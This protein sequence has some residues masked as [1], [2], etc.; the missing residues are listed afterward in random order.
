MSS[1][2]TTNSIFVFVL[3]Q[4][5]TPT[6]LIRNCDEVGLFDDLQQLNPFEETF[7]RALPKS[8]SESDVNILTIQNEDTLHT[9]NVMQYFRVT[10]A[11]E[12]Q[13]TD[14]KTSTE[15]KSEDKTI[16][17]E[18]NDKKLKS[19]EISVIKTNIQATNISPA[20]SAI[21]TTAAVVN[22]VSAYLIPISKVDSTVTTAN[23]MNKPLKRLCPKVS[24]KKSVIVSNPVK[25]KLKEMLIKT[26]SSPT[27]NDHVII[28]E[29]D[30]T[31]NNKQTQQKVEN[32]STQ[33]II[34]TTGRQGASKTKR[35]TSESNR[36]A[37]QRYRRKM[38]KEQ[39]LLSQ[40]NEELDAENKRL[41]AEVKTLQKI[42][43]SHHSCSVTRA[44]TLATRHIVDTGTVQTNEIINQQVLYVI[45][46]AGQNLNKS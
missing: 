36:A 29:T 23:R 24:M 21:A 28:N 30:V 17:N 37:A 12:K 11:E 35:K 33:Q 4:T 41:R 34:V 14:S 25:D 15:V 20:S 13:Q 19:S 39:H 6:R 26:K 40:R 31:K 38:K 10:S 44:S 43:S 8:E 27:T 7:R 3:D 16:S 45:P 42:L 46:V 22:L 18:E 32:K 9:P 1:L 5:P 2:Q